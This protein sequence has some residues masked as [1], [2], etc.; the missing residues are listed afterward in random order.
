M[1]LL[2]NV[3]QKCI[4]ACN[5]CAQACYE[6]FEVCLGES[7]VQERTNYISLLI[8]CAGMCQMSAAHMSMDGEFAMDHC[9][10]CASICDACAQECAMFK[11]D[12]C[13]E[14]AKVCEECATECK[15]MAGM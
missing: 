4:D 10:V 2:S 9:K 1:T 12:H 3:N 15:S 14:C 13:T 5:R 6:C 11:D 7:D 8:E